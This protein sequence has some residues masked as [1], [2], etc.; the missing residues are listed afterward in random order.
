MNW[1]SWKIG[2]VN[3]AHF[4]KSKSGYIYACTCSHVLHVLAYITCRV[5]C[6]LSLIGSTNTVEPWLWMWQC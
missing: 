5:D 1:Q 6:E 4:P 2:C 3:Y